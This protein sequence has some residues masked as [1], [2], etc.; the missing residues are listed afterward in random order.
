MA[1]DKNVTYTNV[2]V[3]SVLTYL[4]HCWQCLC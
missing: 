3:C 1:S 4:I 2:P